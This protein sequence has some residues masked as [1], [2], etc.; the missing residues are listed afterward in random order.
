MKI[1]YSD[2]ENN[3]Y[4]MNQE[5]EII[6][7]SKAIKKEVKFM[8][9]HFIKSMEEIDQ[10]FRKIMKS[11]EVKFY[12]II[13]ELKVASLQFLTEEE[14]HLQINLTKLFKTNY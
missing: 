14:D 7:I 10:E 8:H 11:L 13:E 3:S 4:L 12:A 2:M 6:N 5:S 1:D 9:T